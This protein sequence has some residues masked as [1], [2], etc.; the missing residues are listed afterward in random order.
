MSQLAFDTD[1]AAQQSGNN[2]AN[3]GGGHDHTELRSQELVGVI[4]HRHWVAENRSQLSVH[5]KKSR[6]AR[7]LQGKVNANGY[8]WAAERHRGP[9]GF[10]TGLFLQ[11][12]QSSG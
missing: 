3:D 7:F 2:E 5:P 12:C 1:G 8:P 4:E 6:A 11:P 9:P 10:C